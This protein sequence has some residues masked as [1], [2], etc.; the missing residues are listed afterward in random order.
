MARDMQRRKAEGGKR[1]SAPG[2]HTGGRDAAMPKFTSRPA[3]SSAHRGFTLVEMLVVITIIGILA[4]LGTV[5]VFKALEAAKRARIKVEITNLSNAIESYRLKFGDY[6]PS[7]VNGSDTFSQALVARHLS[8]AFPRCN[9]ATEIAALPANSLTPAEALVFWLTSISKDPTRPLS[10]PTTDRQVL[11]DFDKTRLVVRKSRG[12]PT[13]P[14]GWYVSGSGA[15]AVL[16]GY[17]LQVYLDQ[18]GKN[19]PF[20][21]FEARGYLGHA[22]QVPNSPLML[23]DNP[24]QSQPQNWY[25]Y[26]LE[27]WDINKSNSLDAGTNGPPQQDVQTDSSGWLPASYQKI[28]A[29]PKS[30]Q[31]ISAGLDGS[32]GG[33]GIPVQAKYNGKNVTLYYKSFPTGG[34]IGGYDPAGGDD[35][36]ITNFSEGQLGDAKPQ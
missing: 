26:L 22:V 5:A 25:P 30:F 1:P 19:T 21:Y 23:D 24:S 15:S 35:D 4:S 13:K 12:D 18:S 9:V 36:N 16:Q 31:I 2:D 33:P 27:P 32:F 28:C 20:A 3:A 11:Y 34:V 10:A 7:Y 6:P 14:G 29:N 8:K 17:N